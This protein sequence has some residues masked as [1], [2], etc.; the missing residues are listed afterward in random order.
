MRK[1]IHAADLFIKLGLSGNDEP[2]TLERLNKLLFFALVHH[3]QRHSKPLF[4]SPIVA[5]GDGPVLPVI[6]ER[7]KGRG[8]NMI[9]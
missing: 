6:E 9:S 8:K 1:T 5:G 4:D 2:M 3:L 7:F